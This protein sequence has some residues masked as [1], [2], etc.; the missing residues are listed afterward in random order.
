MRSVIEHEEKEPESEITLNA[1]TLLGIFFGLVLICG[2]FF[3]LGYSIGRRGAE[4]PPASAA[5]TDEATSVPSATQSPKPSAMESLK[6]ADTASAGDS[7]TVTQTLDSDTG[8]KQSGTTSPVV[9]AKTNA[10]KPAI[11]PTP[12]PVQKPAPQPASLS[13]SAPANSLALPVAAS[14]IMVQ[15]AAVSHQE[16]ANALASALRLHGYSVVI[17]NEP[18]DK[19]LHVQVGPFATR[20][21]AKAMRTNLVADGYNAI[22]KP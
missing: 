19:L 1:A 6:T 18:Q 10:S 13:V 16:D 20:D 4:T 9:V 11:A 7:E 15:I 17:R 5:S 22:L 14:A 21:E 3:G 12:Q 2:V 8:S